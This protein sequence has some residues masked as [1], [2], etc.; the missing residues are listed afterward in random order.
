MRFTFIFFGLIGFVTPCSNKRAANEK[1]GSSLDS[2]SKPRVDT[3]DARQITLKPKTFDEINKILYDNLINGEFGPYAVKNDSGYYV[4]ELDSYKARLRE[5]GIFSEEFFEHEEDRVANC[6][7]DLE[8]LKY[9][10]E[11]ELG[12]APNSCFF[13]FMYWLRSQEHPD[14][15]EIKN[16]EITGRDAKA[17]MVFYNVQNKQ[18]SYWDNNVYLNIR[19]SKREG[20]WRVIEIL[21]L[22]E[23]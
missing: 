11:D 1:N 8:T 22:P 18:K 4:L 13:D 23:N 3:I 17:T 20:D 2:I 10:G 21:R 14:G 19:Y 9:K 6:K 15:Y 7:R 16:L 5:H 12:W